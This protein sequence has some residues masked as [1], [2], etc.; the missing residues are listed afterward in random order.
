MRV[1]VFSCLMKVK[2]QE[3]VAGEVLTFITAYLPT[4]DKP[5]DTIVPIWSVMNEL[6][7]DAR[8]DGN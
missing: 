7:E 6:E 5:D 2:L 8:L 3:I 1:V 4:R